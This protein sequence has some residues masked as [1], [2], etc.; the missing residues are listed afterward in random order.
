[1]SAAELQH[2]SFEELAVPLFDQLYNFAQ[3]LTKDRTET[4]DLVQE[5]YS[6]NSRVWTREN[7]EAGNRNEKIHVLQNLVCILCICCA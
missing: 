5:T 4:E 3:W 1:M 6:K 7:S 2:G